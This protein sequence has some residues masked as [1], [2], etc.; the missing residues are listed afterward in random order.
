MHYV[1]YMG[2]VKIL[3]IFWQNITIWASC[4]FF[5]FRVT[6]YLNIFKLDVCL[7]LV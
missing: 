2:W 4:F 7:W 3:S 1:V 5:N 6:C